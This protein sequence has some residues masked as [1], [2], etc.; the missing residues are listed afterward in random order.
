L[1][2][3]DDCRNVH[4]VRRWFFGLFF[5]F[6]F[7]CAHEGQTPGAY[8]PTAVQSLRIPGGKRCLALLDRLGMKYKKVSPRGRI[9]TPVEITGDIAG[10]RYTHGGKTSMVCDCRLALALQWAAPVF[11]AWHISEVQHYGAFSDR[12]TRRGRPSLHSQGLALDVAR[13]DFPDS[14]LS[15]A[16]AYGR[17]WGTGC[18][19]EAPPINQ[20]VC[21]L[22]GLG[23][24]RELITPDHD[25][26]HRDHVHLGIV[27]L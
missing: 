17:G 25:S 3:R 6:A 10:V 22:R 12:T 2:G 5:A 27:P 20:V 1:A 14:S 13:F 8:D 19:P 9:K 15:V 4:A 18:R 7:G 21:Q 23:L 16:S 11:K 26:D 24:F